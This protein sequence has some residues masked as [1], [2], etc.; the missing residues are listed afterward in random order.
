[1]A[2]PTITNISNL[3]LADVE[4]AFGVPTYRVPDHGATLVLFNRQIPMLCGYCLRTP[5]KSRGKN[6]PPHPARQYCV[7]SPGNFQHHYTRWHSKTKNGEK[8]KSW[9]WWIPK[10][11]DVPESA[12]PAPAPLLDHDSD[13]DSSPS[14]KKRKSVHIS[15]EEVKAATR[16]LCKRRLAGCRRVG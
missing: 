14:P 10:T 1:M 11:G 4:D 15:A 5:N 13:S 16:A 8:D 6:D 7:T 12:A 3:T 9:A 2:D